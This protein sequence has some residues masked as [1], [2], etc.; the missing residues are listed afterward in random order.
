MK[1]KVTNLGCIK[2]AEI[3]LGK[4]TLLSGE[5]NTGKT[6]LTYA[7]YGFLSGVRQNWS[8]GTGL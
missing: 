6:Y 1:F 5:N 8:A 4:L 3:E 7:L 2:S